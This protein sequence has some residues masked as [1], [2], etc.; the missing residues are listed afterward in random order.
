MNRKYYSRPTMQVVK[1]RPSG[2]L[3]TSTESHGASR[4]SYGSANY[5]VDKSEKNAY[6]EWEWN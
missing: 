3:M 1:L 4:T 5:G 6:G 2:M